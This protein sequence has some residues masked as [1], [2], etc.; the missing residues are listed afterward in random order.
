M[1]L[2]FIFFFNGAISRGLRIAHEELLSIFLIAVLFP[3]QPIFFLYV[4]F[5]EVVLNVL[6]SL[7]VYFY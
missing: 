4:L 1:S 3:I 2:L 6:C 5:Y 7:L